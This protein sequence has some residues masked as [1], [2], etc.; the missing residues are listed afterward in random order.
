[1]RDSTT[2]GLLLVDKPAGVT[3]HDV[4]LAA[5]RAFSESR[6]G[7]AGTLDPFATGLLVL[8]LGRATRLL[9]HL[10]GVP[11][12]Y[13]ATIALGSETE[14]D[15]LEGAVVREAPPASDS[16]IADVIPQLT[17]VLDQIP[18]AYSAKRVD[19][20]R[21]YEAARAGDALVLAPSRVEVFAWRDLVR[22]GD[23]LRVTIA[24]GRG[25]Y[26]R[27]LAR[28]LG[29]LTGSAAH[30]SALRRV[31]SGP[32]HVIDA[33]SLD[34][35]RG[36]RATLRPALDALPTIPHISLAAEDAER[37]LRGMTVVRAAEG[38]S[39]ALVDAR[40]GALVAFAEASGDAW[41]PRVVMRK[42]G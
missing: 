16:A 36:G 29:R 15:D 34:D 5:R 13:D 38:A 27:A 26:I 22:E 23:R 4:V 1:M 39:A 7:H 19:G 30:L 31:R 32:F 21:A 42:V 11:K 18:P 25:T 35:V 6:I 9:P 8:L 41:Q 40:S 28:D 24:C 14:T 33:V 10:D 2:D 12:E 17:G 20:R 3:S 37:V